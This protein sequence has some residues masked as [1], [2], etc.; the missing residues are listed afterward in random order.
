MFIFLFAAEWTANI[1]IKSPLATNKNPRPTRLNYFFYFVGF[2][3]ESRVQ[4]NI[5]SIWFW[6][7]GMPKLSVEEILVV[8]W[9]GGLFPRDIRIRHLN[10]SH[11]SIIVVTRQF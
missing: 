8:D 6:E 9:A 3:A 4:M 1:Q 5:S 10:V 11:N 2:R 7:F